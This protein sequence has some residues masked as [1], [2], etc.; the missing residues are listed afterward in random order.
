[1]GLLDRWNKKITK[2]QLKKGDAKSAK[3]EVKEDD[4]K[5]EAAESKVTPVS[6]LATPQHLSTILRP[7]ITE[8]AAH[9]QA[10]G[11][12]TFVVDAGCSKTEVVNAI[13]NM[14]DVTPVR[15]NMTNVQG[16]YIRFGRSLGRRSDF[17]KAIVT[18]PKGKTLTIH[19]GV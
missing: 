5:H 11:K 7:L 16:K 19:E 12:Y 10:A 9:A 4:H 15:V 1:M 2:S 6:K 8:K 3:V 18:L 14:Y 17:K 13:K